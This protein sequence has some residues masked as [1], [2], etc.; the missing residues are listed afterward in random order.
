[1]GCTRYADP[2]WRH[3]VPSLFKSQCS[4]NSGERRG[5]TDS[6]YLPIEECQYSRKSMT[7][8]DSRRELMTEFKIMDEDPGCADIET[9]VPALSLFACSLPGRTWPCLA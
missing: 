9:S 1:M 8:P 7:A 3:T 2:L 4:S 6:F 5:P